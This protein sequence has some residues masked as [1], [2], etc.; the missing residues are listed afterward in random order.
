MNESDGMLD[1]CTRNHPAGIGRPPVA[2]TH[3]WDKANFLDGWHTS[4][5]SQT[6]SQAFRC[7]NGA[8]AV[9]NERGKVGTIR[10]FLGGWGEGDDGI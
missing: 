9:L 4:W 5:V 8:S 6:V 3:N 10:G 1:V 2:T 7:E